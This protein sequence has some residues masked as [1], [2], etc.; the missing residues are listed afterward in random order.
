MVKIL[1]CYTNAFAFEDSIPIKVVVHMQ[2]KSSF[3]IYPKC[4]ANPQKAECA[5]SVVERVCDIFTKNDVHYEKAVDIYE[6]DDFTYF[7]GE[8]LKLDKPIKIYFNLNVCI[9]KNLVNKIKP[10]A[11]YNA[12]GELQM[13]GICTN[14]LFTGKTFNDD[15]KTIYIKNGIVV[16][17][18][19]DR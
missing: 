17:N 1:D 19:Y 14:G 2:I 5:T 4:C 6:N 12:K 8:S 16:N 11:K 10:I 13:N 3:I 9:S 18:D 7:V 15:G